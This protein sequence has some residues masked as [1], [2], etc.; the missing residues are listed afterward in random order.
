MDFKK[1]ILRDQQLSNAKRMAEHVAFKPSEIK[2]LIKLFYDKDN[3]IS[4][5]SAWIVSHI[6]KLD[7]EI[8]RRVTPDLIKYLK[9]KNPNS[10]T[11]RCILSS[12]QQIDIPEKYCSVVFD[13]CMRYVKNTTL[14]HAVRA[15]SINIMGILCKRYPELKPEV[16]LILSELKTFPQPGSISASIR[17]TS[18]IL[19][20]L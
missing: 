16:K 2:K 8:V 5:R 20:K 6:C 3:N 9:T 10:P 7:P 12:L 11:V 14:P 19:L 1:E 15:F 13:F 17:N 18:K 4:M